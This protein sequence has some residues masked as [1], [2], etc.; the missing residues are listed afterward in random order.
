[1][2]CR[3]YR[4]HLTVPDEQRAAAKVQQARIHASLCPGCQRFAE[5]ITRTV[6]AVR[7]VETVT[8]PDDFNA[9]LAARLASVRQEA[10]RPGV[11]GSL[12]DTLRSPAPSLQPRT[13]LASVIVLALV[14]TGVAVALYPGSQLGVGPVTTVAQQEPANSPLDFGPA[15]MSGT[16]AVGYSQRE[17]IMQHQSYQLTSPLRD[18]AGSYWLNQ[19]AAPAR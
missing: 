18:Y 14:V 5:L 11:V 19:S 12:L 6:K 15:D 9:R 16:H 8:T 7:S 13:V 10:P 1:M 3:K 17:V 4:F 2:W